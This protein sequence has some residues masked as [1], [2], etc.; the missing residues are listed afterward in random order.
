[1]IT[2]NGAN[3]GTLQGA[4]EEKRA[5]AGALYLDLLV[6]C[7]TNTIYKDRSKEKDYNEAARNEG[8][9][10][11]A[12]AHT[13]IGVARMNT[14]RKLTELVLSENIPGDLIETGVWRGGA[15][16]LMRGVLKAYGDTERK[17]FVADSFEGL[18]APS[19]PVDAGLRLHEV[20]FLAVSQEEVVNNFRIYGLLDEQVV[21]VKG[22]FKD[23]LSKLAADRLALVRLDGDMYESTMQAIEALYPRLSI[24]GFLIVDDYGAFPQCKHAIDDYRERHAID[25]LIVRDRGG[26]I[27]WQKIC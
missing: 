1:L 4:A 18:P 13:M 9:D 26:S 24:G 2:A 27:Y 12:V 8:S 21:F 15:C 16:I 25:E 5:H 22:W 17:V 3:D 14:L 11:P 6:K 23:T 7:V 10:W 19:H 20:K